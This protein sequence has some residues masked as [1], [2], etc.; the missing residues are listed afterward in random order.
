[1]PKFEITATHSVT[2]LFSIEAANREEAERIVMENEHDPG[3]ADQIEEGDRSIGS[4]KQ[5]K[6]FNWEK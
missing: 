4:V 6:N 3:Q 1:M 5:V 2:F